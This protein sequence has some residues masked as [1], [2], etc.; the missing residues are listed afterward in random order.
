MQPAFIFSAKLNRNL[1]P[2][3]LVNL[4]SGKIN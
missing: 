2:S 3:T 4:K 1:P